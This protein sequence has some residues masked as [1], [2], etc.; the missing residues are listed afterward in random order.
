MSQLVFHDI[1]RSK[2]YKKQTKTLYQKAFPAEERL[3]FN[4]LRRLARHENAEF[5][6]IYDGE[7]FVGLMYNIH[8]QDIV[9][10]FYFAI[11]ETMR[12]GGYG[13]KVLHAIKEKYK[14]SRLV[15]AIEPIDCESENYKQRV[16]RKEFY[17]RNGF[18]DLPFTIQEGKVVYDML[19]FSKTAD[20]VTVEE[21]H[22]MMRD[23][24]GKFLYHVYYKEKI[25]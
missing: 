20:K 22:Q 24:L 13:S 16:R 3:P 12:N 18:C 21:Y 15:L 11:D 8:F 6:C 19:Y 14:N 9:Y 5:L 25:K 23:Y 2:A 10:I 4:I 17:K 1:K 7:T